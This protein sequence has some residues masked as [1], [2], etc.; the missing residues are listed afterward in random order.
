MMR[1]KSDL[2]ELI[3]AAVSNK[4]VDTEINFSDDSALCVV[5]ASEG[6]PGKHQQRFQIE[7]LDKVVDAKIFHAATR[8]ENNMIVTSGGRVLGVTALGS[9]ISDAQKRAYSALHEISFSG[10]QYR[11]DIGYRAVDRE[12]T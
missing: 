3:Q 7:G 10:A 11:R 2:F 1:L 9:S 4:L 5:L 6:Y 8:L 12:I